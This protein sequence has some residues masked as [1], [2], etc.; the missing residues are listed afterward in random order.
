M[1]LF[2]AD[3]FD[4]V[5]YEQQEGQEF[6]VLA[7]E[8]EGR[9]HLGEETVRQRE[10]QKQQVCQTAGVQVIRVENSYARR[11]NHI[12]EILVNFFSGKR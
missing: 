2:Y 7:I 5:V 11:Y 6:P 3:T 8:L 9:E 1:H 10:L 4:F 12:K